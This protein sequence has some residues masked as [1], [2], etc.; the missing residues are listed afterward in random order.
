M[1]S[2]PRMVGPRVSPV[3]E[4]NL[5]RVV[6]AARRCGRDETRVVGTGQAVL[7]AA[8]ERDPDLIDVIMSTA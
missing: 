8:G 1:M 5:H 6:S 7:G 4:A 2:A 3:D